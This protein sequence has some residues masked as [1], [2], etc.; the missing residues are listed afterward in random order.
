MI[1]K[2]EIF[3]AKK[4]KIPTR[5]RMTDIDPYDEE[6]WGWDK[7]FDDADF[8]GKYIIY[9]IYQKYM[10]NKINYCFSI[11]HNH[12]D[13]YRGKDIYQ[14]L[15]KIKNRDADFEYLIPLTKRE[16]ERIKADKIELTPRGIILFNPNR[17]VPYSDLNKDTYF[18]TKNYIDNYLYE[19]KYI[20]L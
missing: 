16:I 8:K 19:N 12:Y 2:F 15:N 1:K 14:N 20:D 3:E 6:D 9:K 7:G 4:A 18:L 10:D 11:L 17:R 5:I 13:I